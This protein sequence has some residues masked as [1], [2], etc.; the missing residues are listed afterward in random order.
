M[1]LTSDPRLQRV[2]FAPEEVVSTC[3]VSQEDVLLWRVF[4]E[5][6]NGFYIDVGAGD[7]NHGSVTR[8]FYVNGWTGVNI[9]PHPFVFTN[10]LHWRPRDANL[11]A[12]ISDQPGTLPF[13]KAEGHGW[14]LSSF[15]QGAAREAEARGFEVE[16]IEV[17]TR[18]LADVAERYCSDR[19]VDFVKIDVEGYEAAVIRS[20]DWTVFRPRVLCIEAISPTSNTPAFGEWEP[21]LLAAGYIYVL[22][23]GINNYYVR[24]ESMDILSQFNCGLLWTER[25]RPA[26]RDDFVPPWL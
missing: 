5:T 13:Y 9:E 20:A 19:V 26:V 2:R 21:P 12:G 6:S 17:Q 24:E 4:H 8:W 25:W 23:D 15:N 18:T 16:T 11:N 14:G 10:L 7:P 22:F 1:R 3:T